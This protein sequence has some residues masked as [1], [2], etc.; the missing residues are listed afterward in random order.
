MPKTLWNSSKVGKA[1]W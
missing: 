1:D